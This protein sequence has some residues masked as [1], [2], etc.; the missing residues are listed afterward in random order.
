MSTEFQLARLREV[1]RSAAAAS[2]AATP[3][4][5]AVLDSPRL[6]AR[7]R[8]CCTELAQESAR[9]LLER[10]RSETQALEVVTGIASRG[11]DGPFAW[12][13]TVSQ[14]EAAGRLDNQWAN[15]FVHGGAFSARGWFG[16]QDDVEVGAYGLRPFSARARPASLA[17]ADERAV[18]HV[19]NSMRSDAG[20]PLY[21][22]VS[23][24][25]SPRAALSTARNAPPISRA[26][27]GGC[28]CAAQ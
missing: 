7:L 3:A 17:E 9:E 27:G 2:A 24:V 10:L 28:R 20:S 26:G 23:P 22:N 18:Y 16:V 19:V 1:E 25:L 5:L 4:L 13:V 11:G 14:A 8:R 15:R 6:R 21:G 12:D